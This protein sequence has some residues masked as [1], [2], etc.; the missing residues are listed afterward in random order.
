MSHDQ[1]HVAPHFNCLDLSNNLV[2]W[3]VLMVSS[4]TDAGVT[5]V[6]PDQ[7]SHV[8]PDFILLI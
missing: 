2:P 7:T 8:A 4:D 6:S 5:V 3:T 1:R